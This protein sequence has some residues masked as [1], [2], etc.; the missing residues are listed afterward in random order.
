MNEIVR[1]INYYIEVAI[2]R[3]LYFILPAAA[4]L[5]AGAVFMFNMSRNY[6]SEGLLSMEFQPM[7]STLVNPTVANERLQLI[8]HRLLTRESLLSLA[9]KFDLFPEARATLPKVKVAELVRSHLVLNTM[10]AEATAHYGG[11]ATIRIGFNYDDPQTAATV[12]KELTDRIIG[13]HRRVRVARAAEAVE[14]LGREV[15]KLSTRMVA[16][17]AEWTRYLTANQD[18]LPNRVPA[19]LVELQ[20]KGQELTAIEQSISALNA[21]RSLLEGQLRLGI[22]QSSPPS[23]ARTQLVAVQEEIAQKSLTYSPTH[24]ELVALKQKAV[25]LE[26]QVGKE[27]PGE[28]SDLPTN[29]QVS[30]LPEGLALIAEQVSNTGIRR[31]SLKDHRQRLVARIAELNASVARAAEVEAQY[32]AI[33]AEKESLLRSLQ[34]MTNRYETARLGERLEQSETASP[35]ELIETPDVP[36]YSTNSRR[37]AVIVVLGL[38]GLAGLAGI[39]LGDA[40]RKTVRGAF[41]LEELL[42]G[43]ALVLIPDWD[44]KRPGLFRSLFGGKRAPRGI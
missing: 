41:D 35:I 10:V 39:Y 6:Y 5:V 36:V 12:A 32:D 37:V 19:V 13:E 1:N 43:R 7:P 34:D 2:R 25:E 15:K 9:E 33:R 38:A 24:P 44:P 27:K 4:I 23:R 20:A 17:E 3:P 29:A 42:Q 31:D 11:S 16:R 14:F 26:I 28:A 18:A 30:S 21:E 22:E 8:E 40:M